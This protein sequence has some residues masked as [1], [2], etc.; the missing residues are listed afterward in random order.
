MAEETITILRVG[1]EEA[2]KSV[3]DLKQNIKILAYED[4]GNAIFL[5]LVEKIVNHIGGV[6]VKSA[7]GVCS[8]K[9]CRSR[10]NFS[11][12]KNLLNVSA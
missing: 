9:N 8:H 7:Y 6:N 12:Y 10:R 11:S 3:N 4:Y 5:L 1:T 2:V